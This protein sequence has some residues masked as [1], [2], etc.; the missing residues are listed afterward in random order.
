[1]PTFET[2]H[3]IAVSVELYIGEVRVVASDRRDTVVDV[4]P[5]H[6]D[7]RSDIRIAEETQV[8]LTGD[9]L[10]V[11]APRS[12]RHYT[13]FHSQ[14]SIDV[15][16]EL[17]S[18]SQLTTDVSVGDVHGEGRL[19][20]CRIKTAMGAIRLERAGELRLKTSF[21][22]VTVDHGAGPADVATGSGEIRVLQIDGTAVIRNSNGDTRLGDVTGDLRIKA[23]NGSISVDRA[24]RSVVA[25]SATG[26]IR[27]G[28]VVEGVIVLRTAAGGLDVGVRDGTAAWLDVNSQ[29][30]HV[31]SALDATDGPGESERT[32]EVR[33]RTS[34]G[35]IVIH[36]TTGAPASFP[37]PHPL[38]DEAV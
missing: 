6:A 37:D 19:G 20:D 26:D 15:T 18:G 23:A 16:I 27:I 2:P 3:P 29:H 9:R 24:A 25:K 10:T 34:L 31:H 21:G 5:T 14:G 30:G 1:M 13:P 11:R 22:N 28:E 33:A 12:W 4:R 32:V 35:D 36:R 8:E 7:D 17:P 38:R